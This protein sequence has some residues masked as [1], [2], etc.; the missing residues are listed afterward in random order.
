ML[1]LISYQEPLLYFPLTC[2]V[3]I[4]HSRHSRSQAKYKSDGSETDEEKI[5]LQKVSTKTSWNFQNQQ[6]LTKNK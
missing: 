3:Y 6:T 2:R 4:L 5:E 1:I